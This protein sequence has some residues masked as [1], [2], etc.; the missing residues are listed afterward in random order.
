LLAQTGPCTEK[1]V[2]KAITFADDA[3]SFMPLYGKAVTGT[4]ATEE[5]AKKSFF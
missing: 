3:F 2:K 5:A 1:V 4:A